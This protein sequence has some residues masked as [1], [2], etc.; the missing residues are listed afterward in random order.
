MVEHMYGV[1]VTLNT[2]QEVTLYIKK[3]PQL[4]HFKKVKQGCAELKCLYHFSQPL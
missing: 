2:K 1:T 3:T 4:N